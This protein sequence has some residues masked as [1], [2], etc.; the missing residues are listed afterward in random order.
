ML[1]L[2]LLTET[3]TVSPWGRMARAVVDS[4]DSIRS[5]RIRILRRRMTGSR[6]RVLMAMVRAA[7]LRSS[8]T[9]SRLGLLCQPVRARAI[10]LLLQLQNLASLVARTYLVHNNR[11]HLVRNSLLRH[12]LMVRLR[13]GRLLRPVGPL[14]LPAVTLSVQRTLSSLLIDQLARQLSQGLA[15]DPVVPDR[16][17]ALLGDIQMTA[18]I[19]FNQL[20]V[21][22]RTIRLVVF[23]P[24]AIFG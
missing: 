3:E 9:F 14:L 11:V 1:P 8:P 23:P 16:P 15:Q 10:R 20:I 6:S 21:I 2:Q 17:L 4:V 7:M 5:G 13:A 18:L 12:Q 24:I 22:Y 19:V